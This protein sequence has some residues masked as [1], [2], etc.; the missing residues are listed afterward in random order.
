MNL[1]N[2]LL[3][4]ALTPAVWRWGMVVVLLMAA[5]IGFTGIA[6]HPL[7]AHEAFVLLAA[8]TM[9][10]NRDW[11]IPGF[12][13]EY[14]LNKPP[15]NYWLT[16][17]IAW[18][19]G[20]IDQIQPW[21]GRLVSGLAGMGI[22]LLT[23]VSG[24]K[25]FDSSTGL[26]AGLMLA[27]SAGFFYYTHSA[28]PEMLYALFCSMAFT[29]Y[30][31][32]RDAS[33]GSLVQKVTGNGIW[34]AFALATLTKGPHLPAMFLLAFTIDCRLRNLTLRESYALLQPITGLV[35]FV[36]I[37]LPWWWLLHQ[38]IPMTALSGSQ[39]SGSLLTVNPF[40]ALDPYYLYRPF[41]LL[42]P[43]LL[44][45]PALF[46]LSR[47]GEFGRKEK[48]FKTIPLLVLVFVLPAIMLSFGPQKR[49]YY[50]LP[51]LMPM[52]L[53]LATGVLEI[54][55]SA[56]NSKSWLRYLVWIVFLFPIASI[57]IVNTSYVLSKERMAQQNLA[58]A[59]RAY[60]KSGQPLISLDVTP[61]VFV[62]YT[63]HSVI[64][65]HSDEEL[66][67]TLEKFK[68]QPLVLLLPTKRIENLPSGINFSV[69]QQI[70]GDDESV[71]LLQIN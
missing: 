49:W 4:S 19:T 57:V 29:A 30:I 20:S 22:V 26:L 59:A 18:V 58:I 37:A 50:M 9:H 7:E 69:L 70:K 32:A 67:S 56:Q 8:Q 3:R 65:I 17:F 54:F 39:V 11:V 64:H 21:H 27:T 31:Y 41:Q 47:K 35:I 55:R 23:M 42:S 36:V 40:K 28:R 61:E 1:I 53:L 66:V 44:F 13:G 48:I 6:L 45:I 16:A 15:M 38:R 52:F 71:S 10:D 63:E 60:V 25:L 43:W 2:I 34:L 5:V 14:H 68:G 24:R 33:S 46:Y 51:S 12:N 62:Y